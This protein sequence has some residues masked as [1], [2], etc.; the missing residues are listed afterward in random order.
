VDLS[1]QPELADFTE[2][3]RARNRA[4]KMWLKVGVICGVALV[5]GI[6][7]S[8]SGTASASVWAP[9]C[10]ALAVLLV[11]MVLVVQPL[12]VRGFWRTNPALRSALHARVDPV[13][14]ITVTGLSTG[15]HPWAVVHNFLETDRVFVVQISGY[16][17]LGFLL[18]AK[19]ALPDER[20]VGAL[21]DML[22]AGIA[23]AAR[24]AP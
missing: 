17:R 10:F 13:E 4:R 9:G 1:W 16:Q 23:G 15:T 12:S 22:T 11:V 5:A 19:R 6:V 8:F 24:V 2:A 21:R 14:G 3:F 20:Q 7:F 18:L